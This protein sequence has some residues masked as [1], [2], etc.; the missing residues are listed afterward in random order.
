MPFHVEVSSSPHRARAFNLDRAGLW[1]AILE[2]WVAGRVFEFGE[3]EWNPRESGLTILEGKAMDPPDLAFGQGWSNALRSA[4]DVTR[5]AMDSAELR[6]P[7]PAAA[8]VE[9]ASLEEALSQLQSGT[10]PAPIAWSEATERIDGRD[11]AVAAVILVLRPSGPEPP[12]NR[13]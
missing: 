4:R 8:T 2:P 5:E 9:A 12:R 3:R 13:G 7:A 10:G 1:Q 6:L 11:P